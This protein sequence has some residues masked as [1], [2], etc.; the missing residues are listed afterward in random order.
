M[1]TRFNRDNLAKNLPDAYR[2]DDGSNNAKILAAEK[3]ASDVLRQDVQI[4]HDSLDIEKAFGNTLDL[5]GEM[6]GQPRGIATDEQYRVLIKN[7]ILIGYSN[8]DFNSIVIAISMIF[9]CE[10]E[11]VL[12]LEHEDEPCVVSLE[13]LP[14]DKLAE[15]NIDIDT[16]IE[17]IKGLIPSGVR[18]ETISF[19]GTFEFS[20]AELVYDE[21]TGFADEA[22]TIGGT[23]GLVAD[24]IGGKLPV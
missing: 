4:I 15:N 14:I 6:L 19:A 21:E 8:P 20:G 24:N 9:G 22:Q 3:Y 12:L 16:A 1:I 17:I 11:D 18:I 13:G 7:K 2:K 23:L 5:Y 10:P